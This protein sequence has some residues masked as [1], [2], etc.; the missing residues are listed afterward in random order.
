MSDDSEFSSDD[1][2]YLLYKEQ[3]LKETIQNLNKDLVKI[4]SK[5]KTR[6]ID[7]ISI[8]DDDCTCLL[9]GVNYGSSSFQHNCQPLFNE[10]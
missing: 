5:L 6:N 7:S 8:N 2:E 1:D 3:A 10:K 4:Q 9:C